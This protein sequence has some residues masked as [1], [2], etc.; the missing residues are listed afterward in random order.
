VANDRDFADPTE[1]HGA[2]HI[3]AESR[4][5]EWAVAALRFPG[6]VV[7]QVMCGIRVAAENVVRIYGDEGKI[8][9]PAPWTLRGSSLT[10]RIIVKRS[11]GAEPQEVVVEAPADPWA[12]EADTVANHLHAR[13]AAMPAMSW[14]DSL[15]NLQ[16]LDRWREAIGLVYDFERL[17]SPVKRLPARP[18]KVRDDNRMRYG[19]IAGVGKPISRLVMGVDNQKSM[20][21]A[22]VMFD[23]FFERGGT[24]FDTA[25]IYGAGQC[26]P[27]LGRWIED[28][29]LRDQVV[30]LGKGAHTPYCNP[31]GISAQLVE[32]LDR[33]RTDYLDI[34][35]LHRDNL[36]IPVDEFIG[37][38]NEHERAGR[39][40]VFGASNWSID[41]LEAANDYAKRNGLKGFAAISN[42]FSLARMI[43]PPWSGCVSSSD[44]AWRAW[45]TKTQMPLMAWSSQARGF[46]AGR[47][48]PSDL[49]DPELVR[50]W[51]SPDNFERLARVERMAAERGV[52]PIAI[53]L[54]WVLSQPFPTFPLIGPRTL[55]ET[56]T[57]LPGLD[58]RLLPEEVG[59]LNLEE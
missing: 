57:S 55:S 38:L 10:S 35:M 45:L 59:W 36:A 30:I 44:A 16:T 33:L 39:M 19:E 28:R 54:A 53:A 34:Y 29:G 11:D 56:R 49:S 50:C 43:A 27:V 2:G 12:I 48:A 47:A 15:G 7:A 58:V 25:Y 5:D 42:N 21:H 9:V 13:Q 6:D 32:S 8:L 26:E 17:Q 22:A 40:R 18:L 4:V 24:C 14:E 1:V 52:Q 23:D 51:Y 46:F 41:R 3:G 31:D 37:V 20:P